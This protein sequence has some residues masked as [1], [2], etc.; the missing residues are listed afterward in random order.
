MVGEPQLIMAIHNIC[1]NR[2]TN[3]RNSKTKEW[4]YFWK[5]ILESGAVQGHRGQE[6]ISG[7]IEVFSSEILLCSIL[8]VSSLCINQWEFLL[9]ESI[10]R[11]CHSGT[12]GAEVRAHKYSETKTTHCCLLQYW[13]HP[14]IGIVSEILYQ[15]ESGRRENLPGLSTGEDLA[16]ASQYLWHGPLRPVYPTTGFLDIFVHIRLHRLPYPSSSQPPDSKIHLSTSA[17]K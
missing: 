13:S 17:H 16:P 11:V 1:K 6:T 2:M 12:L 10:D 9:G 14:G 15:I 7:G 3:P 5:P 8:M 4:N